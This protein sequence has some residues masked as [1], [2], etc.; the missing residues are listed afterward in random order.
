MAAD[1]CVVLEI[2]NNRDAMGTLD[3]DEK[4]VA[5]TDILGGME[6][7]NKAAS[8]PKVPRRA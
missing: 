3:D 2:S 7:L 5:I 4:G 8:A 6:P 1:V